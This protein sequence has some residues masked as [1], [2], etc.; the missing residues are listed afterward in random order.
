[1]TKAASGTEEPRTEMETVRRDWTLVKGKGKRKGKPK[2]GRPPRP[3][4]ILIVTTAGNTGGSSYA[5][6]LK[7]IKGNQQLKDLGDRV[8]VVKKTEKGH[9]LLELQKGNSDRLSGLRQTLKNE[10]GTGMEIRVLTAANE[11]VVEILDMDEIA[12]KLDVLDAIKKELGAEANSITEQMI[13]MRSSFRGSQTATIQLANDLAKKLLEVGKLRVSWSRC[14]VREKLVPTRC[15][16]CWEFGHKSGSC[17]SVVDRSSLCFKC[18]QTD[19][20]AKDCTNEARC[21]LCLH[22]NPKAE[23]N[24]FAG[25]GRCPMLRSAVQKLK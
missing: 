1:M 13:A 17:K 12:T 11:R 7:D 24:H 20:K 8:S 5:A 14:R 18:G 21:E 22:R 2:R 10:L 6:V 4:A 9:L 23:A 15:F 25:R 3:D 19:H 16:K